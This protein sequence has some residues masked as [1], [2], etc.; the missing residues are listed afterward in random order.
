MIDAAEIRSA[1]PGHW[2]E[3]LLALS[4]IPADMLDGN[5]YSCPK[6]GGT[7]LAEF[8]LKIVTSD[9]LSGLRRRRCRECSGV[10]LSKN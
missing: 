9:T 10:F 3:P 2:P 8:L 5:H 1:A 4:E 7:D 6:R